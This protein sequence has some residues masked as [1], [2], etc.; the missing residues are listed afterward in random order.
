MSSSYLRID[1][2]VADSRSLTVSFSLSEDLNRYFNEPHVFH[3]EY[4]QDISGVPEGILV[5]PF[6]TNVLPIIWLKDAVL[7]VPKLD[8]VFYESIPDIKRGYADMS[9]MLTFKGRVEVSELEEHDVSPSEQ[10]ASFFSG[11]VDAFTTLIRH[12]EEKPILLTLRGSDIKL[13]DEAGWQ[14]VHQHTL[15]TAEQFNLPEP[16]FI[17]SNFRTFLREGELTNLVKASGDNYWHGYQ[18]GIGLIGH[19]APLA[20]KC[21]IRAT[22]IASTYT[23]KDNVISATDPS[24]D[25]KV[26]LSP[27]SVVHDGY[28]WDRQRKIT[29]IV[30]YA[31]RTETYPKLRVCWITSGG[32]NCCQCEK[33]LRTMYGLMAEGEDPTRYG[34]DPLSLDPVRSRRILFSQSKNLR[35]ANWEPILLRFRETRH[36]ADDSRVNWIF[37]IKDLRHCPIQ[38]QLYF[39]RRKYARKLQHMFS[40]IRR[41]LTG[42]R[43]RKGK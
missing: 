36:Y 35:L 43:A 11:G 13:S 12:H 41:L 15:E 2:V 14:V 38:D 16:V 31:H 34:F 21:K 7:Q 9:P 33:C 39:L 40:N 24:I 8:R 6:I 17:T 19:A 25:D 4:S 3:V 20:F 5:I 42:K 23:A 10:V 32:K 29:A 30:E 27:S 28:E 1:S 18:C 22:Y 26:C 37:R